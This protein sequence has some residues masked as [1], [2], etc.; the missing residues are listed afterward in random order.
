MFSIFAI[1]LPAAETKAFLR[2][3]QKCAR[4][5]SL[6]GAEPRPH[7][8]ALSRCEPVMG[9]SGRPKDVAPARLG[10]PAGA[11]PWSWL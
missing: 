9:T 3:L 11:E 8:P 7:K 2:E 10:T 4:G 6:L 1:K 5:C